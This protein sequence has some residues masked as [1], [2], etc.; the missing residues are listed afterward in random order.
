MTDSASKP[1]AGL[2]VLELARVLAGP[3]AGQTLA[4]LGASVIK[5]ERPEGGDDTRTW[6]P[7]F[8]ADDDGPGSA[9][10]FHATNRGKRSI[11]I[12]YEKPEGRSIALALATKADVI[13]ENFKVGGL[14]KYGLD[15]PAISAVNPGVIY[16]SIT[17]FG[18]SGP[19]APR[20]GYDFIVQGMGGIMDL[21]GAPDGEPQKIGVAFA[22]IFTGVYGTIGILAAL[23]RRDAT[24][25]G[26]FIDMALLDTQ[27]AVLAN[28][29]MNYLA[30]GKEPRR[31]GN[32]HPNIVPYQVFHAADGPIIIAAGNDG[33]FCRVCE[34]LGLSHLGADERFKTNARRIAN[35]SELIALLSAEIGKRG[36]AELLAALEAAG[37]PAG[38]VNKL[39]EVFADPQIVARQMRR[40]L[41]RDRGAAVPTVRS[42][43]VI[44]G[45]PCVAETASP[46]LGEHTAQVFDL[47]AAGKDPWS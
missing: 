23:H 19:Y 15:Y 5:I 38:P 43:I 13:I 34:L 27:V 41:E 10:Y 42:P 17:G 37:V 45:E 2:R 30:S 28:Q 11:A 12:D 40:D 31:L 4:D 32:A 3:W 25:I 44:D 36:S 16:C 39:D 22:D 18:Q 29:A 26:A 8:I 33:Q 6:G 35:R 7:P 46:K 21:T 14:A 20:A 24:G 9:A 1:L 47:L